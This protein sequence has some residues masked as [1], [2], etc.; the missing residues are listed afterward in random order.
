MS[1]KATRKQIR[2]SVSSKKVMWGCN[3]QAGFCR[4]EPRL[5]RTMIEVSHWRFPRLHPRAEVSKSAQC[6]SPVSFQA[7]ILSQIFGTDRTDKN[8]LGRSKLSWNEEKYLVHSCFLWTHGMRVLDEC[9][10]PLWAMHGHSFARLPELHGAEDPMAVVPLSPL[11]LIRASTGTQENQYL[12]PWVNE[13][14]SSPVKLKGKRYP[15]KIHSMWVVRSDKNYL[16]KVRCGARGFGG[17]YLLLE[18]VFHG[19]KKATAFCTKGLI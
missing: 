13:T 16:G 7:N 9:I 17:G 3:I 5:Q 18:I 15:E 12:V 1:L 11:H 19:E 8:T 4:F 14:Q 6:H 10:L 2:N